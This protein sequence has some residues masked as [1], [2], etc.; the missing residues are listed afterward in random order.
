MGELDGRAASSTHYLQHSHASL[1]EM[2]NLAGLW[3][4]PVQKSGKAAN[5]RRSMFYIFPQ[6]NNSLALQIRQE[7]LKLNCNTECQA[8]W[9][10]GL[11][12][13]TNLLNTCSILCLCLNSSTA[14]FKCKHMLWEKAMPVF[15]DSGPS[16]ALLLFHNSPCNLQITA[17]S[18]HPTAA[19]WLMQDLFEKHYS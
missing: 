2:L 10:R 16:E 19:W 18:C 4:S 7:A 14:D 6:L 12:I 3:H 8:L 1:Q 13:I 15:A 11:K 9:N 5:C 17:I